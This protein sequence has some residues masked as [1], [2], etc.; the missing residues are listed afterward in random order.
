MTVKVTSTTGGAYLNSTGTVTS[1]QGFAG[2]PASAS[3]A[4]GVAN[5]STSSKSWQDLN[6]GEPNPGDTIRYT[7][8]LTETSGIIA[9]GLDVTDSM[10]PN[11]AGFTVVSAPAGATNSS[12]GA[13][14]GANGTGYLNITNITVPAGGSVPVVFDETIAAGTPAGASINNCAAASYPAGIG[15]SP[16]APT[17]ILSPSMV[18]SSGNKQLYLYDGT[19]APA[20][21]LSRAKPA[22]AQASV[23][24]GKAGSQQWTLEPLLQKA[25]TI[26]PDVAP[27]AVIPVDLYLASNT[28]NESRTVQVDVTCSGGGPTYTETKIFDGTAV[29]NPYLATT[30]TLVSFT[31]LVISAN[32][33]CA[34]GQTWNLTVRNTTNGNGTRDVIVYP[35]TGGNN[36][37]LSL[38]SLSVINVDSVTSYIATYPSTSTPA[39]GYFG[40]GQTVYVRAVVSDPFGSF[41]ITSAMVSITNPY[42]VPTATTAMNLVADSGAS[43]RT[44]EYAYTIP[45]A[46]PD[47]S[48]TAAVLARE[49]AENIVSDSGNGFFFVG[50][51]NLLVLKS[52]QTY[53]DP[54][55]TAPPYRRIPGSVME[56]SVIVTNSGRGAAD[57]NSIVLTDAVPANTTMYV[58]TAPGDPVTFTCSAAPACGLSFTYAANVRYTNIFPLPALQAPPNVCGNY[59]YVPSGSYD[60]N[61]RG[62]C[63]NPSG[64]LNGSSGPPDPQFTI[65]Y[66][67][68]VN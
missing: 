51:P 17:I 4:I 50:M 58:D 15:A 21:K 56:Y 29:N 63:I 65:R 62:I 59:T 37:S 47:G 16:C 36:S 28:A 8:T 64:V 66:R 57:N 46:G 19:S 13:G 1:T 61:V 3:V 67:M 10:P 30:P 41:D 26:S 9:T 42:S 54:V 31:N 60:T 5:L 11:T 2:D 55:N 6:G 27:L 35:V 68:R 34:A 49:G 24:I 25:V 52:V 53:S 40:S 38:P 39:S 48:W 12:T 45:G 43:T 32:H 44:F 33:A 23:T 14:T 18:A 7:I 20:Y 22:G